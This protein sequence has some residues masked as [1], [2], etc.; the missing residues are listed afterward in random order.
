MDD[1]HSVEG[2]YRYRY[3]RRHHHHHRSMVIGDDGDDV[4][5]AIVDEAYCGAMMSQ[6]F[7]FDDVMNHYYGYDYETMM[8]STRRQHRLCW[9]MTQIVVTM[10]DDDDSMIM[11]TTIH[12]PNRDDWTITNWDFRLDEASDRTL[13]V[14]DHV[15]VC[16]HWLHLLDICG[17]S[18][19]VVVGIVHHTSYIGTVSHPYGSTCVPL[20]DCYRRIG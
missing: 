4:E 17:A 7:L 12:P 14:D 6:Q 15:S 13:S 8:S 9:W 10:K 16:P 2:K 5:T 19:D 11:W 18:D 1:V 20:T 3:F